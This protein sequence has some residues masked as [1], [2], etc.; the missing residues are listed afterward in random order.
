MSQAFFPIPYIIVNRLN[1]TSSQHSASLDLLI[2]AYQSSIP[3]L[4]STH[5][6]PFIYATVEHAGVSAETMPFVIGINLS[7]IHKETVT[8]TTDLQIG[9]EVSPSV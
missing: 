2:F 3:I 9:I 1:I 6:V 7:T 4:L 5:A 8:K